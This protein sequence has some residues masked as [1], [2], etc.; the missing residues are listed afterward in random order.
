MQFLIHSNRRTI[1]N[2][3]AIYYAL[4]LIHFMVIESDCHSLSLSVYRSIY[5]S[6]LFS[7]IHMTDFCEFEAVHRKTPTM[8]ELSKFTCDYH[9][10]AS[11][12]ENKIWDYVNL[13]IILCTLMNAKQKMT[14]TYVYDV[15][16]KPMWNIAFDSQE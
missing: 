16:P 2:H 12:S 8:P 7:R 9:I 15:Y 5:L 1:F 4:S 14:I 11:L 13:A 6:L 10:F 3:Y